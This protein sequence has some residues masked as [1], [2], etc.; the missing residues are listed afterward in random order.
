LDEVD[1][2][3]RG[4]NLYDTLEE[5]AG[6]GAADTLPLPNGK[7]LKFAPPKGKELPAKGFESG[8]D[9]FQAPP[10]DA[11]SASVAVSPTSQRLQP[12]APF[13]AWNGKDYAGLPVLIKAKG[14]CTVDG[15]VVSEADVTFMLMDR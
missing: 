7:T 2:A 13:D 11:S 12:L 15:E 5:C 9:T 1:A 10:A 4:L 14:K 3:L 8:E 6:R